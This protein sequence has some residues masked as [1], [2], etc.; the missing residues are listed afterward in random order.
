[1]ASISGFDANQVDPH[2]GFDPI[3]NGKYLA[4]IT[5]SEYKPTKNGAGRYLQFEY[6]ILDGQFKGRKLWTRHNLENP[7]TDAVKIAR[8]ELSSICRAVG[9]LTPGDTC[10]LHNL[11]LIINVKVKKR[12]D[13]DENE[14]VI[15]G[16]AKKDQVQETPSQTTTTPPWMRKSN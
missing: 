5:A 12:D 13:S 11:P 16:W 14:N 4:I 9:I 6:Q 3:P 8:S 2:V 10:E 7:S 15:K 1:M